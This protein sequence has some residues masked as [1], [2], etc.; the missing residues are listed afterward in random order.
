MERFR[1]KHGH[2][3]KMENSE[4]SHT[5]DAIVTSVS[6]T[7]TDYK[8]HAPT[9]KGAP[10]SSGWFAFGGVILH[11]FRRYMFRQLG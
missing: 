6:H 3:G 5:S 2:F 9:I 8:G 4:K 11:A 1:E 10:I 7:N